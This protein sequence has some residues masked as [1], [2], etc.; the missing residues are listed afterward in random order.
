MGNGCD[1]HGK[2]NNA[3]PEIL[4]FANEGWN[5][6]SLFIN[7]SPVRQNRLSLSP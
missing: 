4:G 5:V 1:T 7:T 6:V 2:E 3:G